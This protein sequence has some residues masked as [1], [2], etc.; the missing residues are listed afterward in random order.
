MVTAEKLSGKYRE[1][2]TKTNFRLSYAVLDVKEH[3]L[4]YFR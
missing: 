2:Q 1:R 4:A 3:F